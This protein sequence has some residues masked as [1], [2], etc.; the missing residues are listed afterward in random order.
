MATNLR[1]GTLALLALA[2]APGLAA[3]WLAGVAPWTEVT[4][5]LHQ[6]GLLAG[7]FGAT[8]LLLAAAL[9]VRIPRLDQPFGG[10]VALW[11][12]HHLLGLGA[13][14]LVMAHP[15]LLAVAALAESP[16]AA[17]AVLAPAASDRPSWLGWGALI[18]MMIFLAPTFSF[19]GA[20]RYQRWKVV[21]ALSAAAVVL[22]FSHTILLGSSLPRWPWW[23]LGGLTAGA[24]AYRLGWRKLRPGAP[25]T[26]TK[27][28][29]LADRVVELSLLP[30]NGPLMAYEPGQFV[31]LTPLD[32]TLAVGRGE[33]HP[34]TIASAPHETVLRIAIKSLGDA[35]EALQ[36]V[37]PGTLAQI[38][39]PY[40][41]FFEP[42]DAGPALWI[43][44]GIGIT[45]FVGKVRALAKAGA[46]VDVHLVYCAN[47]PSRAYYLDELQQIAEQVPG[48][49][50][51]PHFFKDQ[52]ALDAAWLVAHCADVAKR[53]VHVCGPSPLIAL[54]RDLVRKL[55]VPAA[56]LHSEEFTFL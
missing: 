38:D 5:A 32:P 33:E 1:P 56:R 21:H 20:P 23:V 3:G 43:G 12:V 15:L 54:T 14:L 34:Y 36:R 30:V 35:T 27:V 16:Q 49:H 26:V 55:G 45:P 17:A 13:F 6:A 8:L 40:G 42:G 22:A 53:T 44:G 51:W 41:R 18:A 47:D 29:P 28:E 48:L 2:L 46:A 39:G 25:Y 10:L 11:Q 4:T 9:S 19:F 52:R 24:L 31:Y 50:V 7:V 37:T